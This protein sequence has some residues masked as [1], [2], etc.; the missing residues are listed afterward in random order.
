[1]YYKLFSN[2]SILSLAVAFSER[3]PHYKA[4]PV[5]STVLSI[6]VIRVWNPEGCVIVRKLHCQR[7]F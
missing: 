6:P 1:M 5:G 4:N 3:L 7:E 2:R